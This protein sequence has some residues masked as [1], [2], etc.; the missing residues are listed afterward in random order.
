M[1]FDVAVVGDAQLNEL[2]N[3]AFTTSPANKVEVV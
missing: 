1:V 3:T 2:V